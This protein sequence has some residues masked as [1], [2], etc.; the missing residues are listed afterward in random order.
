[1]TVFHKDLHLGLKLR[2]ALVWIGAMARSEGNI[3]GADICDEL[4]SS[5][6]P[7][8]EVTVHVGV[9]P[10]LVHA[11]DDYRSRDPEVAAKLEALLLALRGP[12]RKIVGQ[13]HI[14]DLSKL[15]K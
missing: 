10:A 4:V 1:M 7:D 3:A 6:P 13:F 2:E 5:L 15:I 12:P 11:V 14:S 9:C 8:T